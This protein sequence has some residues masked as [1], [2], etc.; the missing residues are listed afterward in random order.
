MATS[1]PFALNTGSTISGT[2]QYGNIA[3][4]NNGVYDYT[5]NPGG[6]QWYMGPDEDLGYVIV[7]PDTGYAHEF[8]SGLHFKRS[9]EKTEESYINLVNHFSR[10]CGDPN[11]FTNSTDANNWLKLNGYPTSQIPLV[12]YDGNTVNWFDYKDTGT[13]IQDSAGYLYSWL[14]KANYY[15]SETNNIVN[16][17]FDTNSNWGFNNTTSSIH[18][19]Q[20]WFSGTTSNTFQNTIPQ[21]VLSEVSWDVV[22]MGSNSSVTMTIYS[23]TRVQSSKKT[24][25]STG[26][27]KLYVVP[28]EFNTPNWVVTAV[29]VF[30]IDNMTS[31]RI[32]GNNVIQ[33]TASY[34]PS[35]SSISGIT[36]DGIDNRMSASFTFNQPQTLYMVMN[37]LV[38][39]ST[40]AFIDGINQDSMEI[41]CSATPNKIIAYGGASSGDVDI[42]FGQFHIIRAV[43]NGANSK[44]IID[45]NTPVTGNF[46]TSAA[47]GITL[48]GKGSY[49]S[50][51]FGNCIFKEVIARNTIDT[52]ANEILIYNYLANKHGFPTI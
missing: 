35:Y 15:Y 21:S 3:I 23:N 52:E 42:T 44:I 34:Q 49:T 9:S 48:G 5:T 8:L 1:R 12:I 16:G 45:N 25:Y 7:V 33:K 19:G 26:R 32:Y 27:Y 14:D 22:N 11:S 51:Y 41:E 38:Y 4:G 18:D 10:E 39:S 40:H 30:S 43:F 6:V 17:T 13:T 47:G 37:P 28:D 46:G 29:S 2:T 31:Y 20:L 36:F 50:G 24:I